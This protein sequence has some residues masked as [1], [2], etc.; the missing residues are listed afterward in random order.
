MLE[1]S[2]ALLGGSTDALRAGAGV[3]L[4]AALHGLLALD[5]AVPVTIT[6]VLETTYVL[7]TTQLFGW[8]ASKNASAAAALNSTAADLGNHTTRTRVAINASDA[9]NAA[10]TPDGAARRLSASSPAQCARSVT[11]GVANVTTTV[12]S[13]E[14]DYPL[15]FYAMVG[16]ANQL[17]RL[18]LKAALR[19]RALAVLQNV[20]HFMTF[21]NETLTLWEACTGVPAEGAVLATAAEVA[22]VPTASMPS[23]SPATLRA[24]PSAPAELDLPTLVVVGLLV[25]FVLCC[26]CCLSAAWCRRREPRP[27]PVLHVTLPG[28]RVVLLPLHW[29]AALK[30]EAGRRGDEAR[31]HGLVVVIPAGAPCRGP[32][33]LR[34]ASLHDEPDVV[35]PVSIVSAGASGDRLPR[36]VRWYADGRRDESSCAVDTTRGSGARDGHG[37]DDGSGKQRQRRLAALHAPDWAVQCPGLT[38]LEAPPGASHASPV[39][40]GAPRAVLAVR[41]ATLAE[42]RLVLNDGHNGPARDG[43]PAQQRD[44]L[45]Q[46]GDPAFWGSAPAF[47]VLPAGELSNRL[48]PSN[49]AVGIGAL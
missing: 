20:T 21:F 22:V 33:G 15:E 3:A 35:L 11:V 48:R 19:A 41:V 38:D 46:Q 29:G 28:G 27:L 45:Q 13:L 17:D 31:E 44:P 43:T 23:R 9:L 6:S 26:G 34:S 49:A 42:R 36:R 12:V 8:A 24:A 32:L 47:T 18:A 2:L 10:L 14:V 37:T 25:L 5:E 7:N 4:R 30:R 16:A 39:G 40:A 1:L